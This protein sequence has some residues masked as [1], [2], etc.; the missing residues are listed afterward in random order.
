MGSVRKDGRSGLAHGG[1]RLLCRAQTGCGFSRSV[2]SR[3]AGVS[4]GPSGKSCYQDKVLAV[5]GGWLGVRANRELQRITLSGLLGTQT[6]E[7]AAS[8]GH[9]TPGDTD[10]G[11]GLVEGGEGPICG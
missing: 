10:L 9:R 11:E 2:H 8:W 1:A 7:L 5:F 3:V 4:L 6:L